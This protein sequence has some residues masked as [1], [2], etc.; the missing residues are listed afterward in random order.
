MKSAPLALAFLLAGCASMNDNATGSVTSRWFGVARNGRPA[1]LWTLRTRGLEIDVTDYG[2]TLVAVRT[3]DRAGFLGDVVLGFDDVRGYESPDNQYF[4]CTTGRVCNRIAKGQ[5]TLDGYTYVLA[6]NN[7]PNHLHGGAVRSFDKVF[8]TGEVA[9]GSGDAPAVRFRY[10][11]KD[12]E[13]GYPGNLEVEVTYSLLPGPVLQVVTT[14]TTDRRTPVNVTNHAYWNLAGA[15]SP[16]VLEHVL[17]IDA[18]RYT[19]TDDTLIPTGR[20]ASVLGGPLDFTEPLAIGVRI[21]EL[22]GTPTAGFDHNYVLR[23][24]DGVREVAQLREPGSGRWMTIATTE[25]GLQ[26]YSGNHLHGQHGK[27]GR[28]YPQRSAVC[29]ETQHFPDSVNHPQ[30][31]STIL[32]PGARYRTVTE[33]RFGAE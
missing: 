33:W 26:L 12:G 24:G 19:P 25:P 20:I 4:G 1:T 27:G 5:F 29:L 9:S 14:A 15:G 13:E 31:P 32:E 2:A 8:W 16:T 6:T 21:G 22:T 11:S 18:E 23:P 28:A 3:P 10:R 7:G 17:R 30:F